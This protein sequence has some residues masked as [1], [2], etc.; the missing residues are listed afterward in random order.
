MPRKTFTISKDVIVIGAGPAGCAAAI[1][2]ARNGAQTLL[3]EKNGILG[4]MATAGMVKPFMTSYVRNKKVIDGIFG[5]IVQGMHSLHAALGPFACPNFEN[6]NKRDRVIRKNSQQDTHGTGGHITVF[7]PEILKYLLVVETEKAGVELLLHTLVTDAVLENKRIKNIVAE[8]KSGRYIFTPKIVI[9][10]SGDG[11]VA[12]AAGFDYVLGR[13]EDGVCQ[14]VSVMYTLG[15]IDTERARE[16]ILQNQDQFEWLSMPTL[17]EP[18]LPTYESKQLAG[19][20]FFNIIA[21]AKAKGELELGRNQVTFFTDLRRG[22][23]TINATRVN[24]INGNFV[25]DLTHAEKSA[26]KQ[27]YSLTETLRK[28]VPGFEDCFILA[29]SSV[30]GVRESRKIIGEYVLTREDI[31]EGRKFTDSVCKGSFPIDIH[32]PFGDKGTW[33]ELDDAY[34]IPYRSLIPKGADNLL[35]AGRCISATHDAQASTRVMPTS[36]AI[37]QAAGT[38]AALSLKNYIEKLPNLDIKLLQH[39]LIEQNVIL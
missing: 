5:E 38:A 30:I 29:S 36:M 10:A 31:V 16:Y 23:W 7:D 1:A 21:E 27:V 9:D 8:T 32:D 12:A 37:G 3:L 4:G 15:G 17:N 24:R 14:P 22:E 18:V 2:S 20:G 26:R 11:D 34:T 39:T 19:S 28:Y 6:P 25:E 13:E 35:V 33:I